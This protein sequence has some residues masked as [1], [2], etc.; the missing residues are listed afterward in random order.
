[1]IFHTFGNKDNKAVMLIHGMLT[2][3]QIW[4][5]ATEHFA[6]EYYVV[7]P[8][9]DA[10]TEGEIST[11]NSVEEEAQRIGDYIR[12]ELDGKVF[13]LAGLSMG[14]RIAATV[15]SGR[16]IKIDNLVIDGAPLLK[17][18]GLMKTIMKKNYI[19]IIGKSRARDPKVRA[20]F[21]KDFLPGGFWDDYLKIADNMED[22]SITNIIDGV[23]TD[24]DFIKYPEDMRIL[25]MHGTKGNES[26]A[27]KGALKMK[28]HNPHMEIRCF[29]GFAHA[30]LACFKPDKWI[31]E[32]EGFVT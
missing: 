18:N 32:V 21:T 25:F 12:N 30:E 14:G 16:D 6:S 29:D 5:R 26:V 17:V 15:A 28:D 20:S 22:I 31:E 2:P 3:W 11:F 19:S 23:F 10:H 27:R 8:E 24:F 4:N 1:M 7:V 9:L 13:L